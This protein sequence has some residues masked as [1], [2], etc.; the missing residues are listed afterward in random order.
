[1][2]EV[3]ALSQSRVLLSTGTLYGAIKRLLADGWICRK[4]LAMGEIASRIR[5]PHAAGTC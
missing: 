1:M 5:L 4:M 3:E 2:K